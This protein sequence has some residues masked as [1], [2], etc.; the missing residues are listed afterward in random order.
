M[1]FL[2]LSP[3]VLFSMSV[4]GSALAQDFKVIAINGAP[5]HTMGADLF[6][7]AGSETVKK[8]IPDG[9]APASMSSLVLFAVEDAVLIDTGAGGTAWFN[10]LTELGV[11]PENVKLIL[12]THF[13]G[14]HIGGL[15]RGDARRF[16]HAT[17][18]ASTLECDSQK[19]AFEKIK[20]AYGNDL[21]KFN[22][23][24][25]VF[26]N[27][28]IKVKALDAVGHTLGHTAFLIESKQKDDDKFLIVG[29]LLHAAVLQ[30]PV[31]EA[32]ASFDANR[33]KAVASRKRLLDFAA[34]EKIHNGGMHL[35][36]PS[37]GTVKKVDKGYA[38][39]PIK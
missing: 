7:S 6:S 36:P 26:A 37:I 34:Q 11:K 28:L 12:L 13:H 16:P 8:Y 5:G 27:S 31:P 35:P 1:K 39:E 32:C 19:S 2:L 20:V 9:G 33:E 25:E 24:D 21:K 30:F 23:D 29:D 4:F 22:F 10:K 17:V 14:D 3:M 18:L 38:F 15:F